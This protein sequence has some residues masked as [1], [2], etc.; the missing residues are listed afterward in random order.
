LNDYLYEKIPAIV[1]PFHNLKPRA[2]SVFNTEVSIR[3]Q[4]FK[5]NQVGVG[6]GLTGIDALYEARVLVGLQE[7]A[8][9]NTHTTVRRPYDQHLHVV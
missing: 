6:K 2:L 1:E 5:T 3:T 4:S 8:N 9:E 7:L